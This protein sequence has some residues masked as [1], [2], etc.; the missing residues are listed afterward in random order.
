MVFCY[1]KFEH[2]KP[3]L[4]LHNFKQFYRLH[5]YYHVLS[6]PSKKLEK[7]PDLQS[8]WVLIVQ[9][10]K[11]NTRHLQKQEPS[12]LH[13]ANAKAP[14]TETVY[15]WMAS[16]MICRG[17]EI[18]FNMRQN[19]AS[20]DA[21]KIILKSLKS[22]RKNCWNNF[23][24][25]PRSTCVEVHFFRP[26]WLQIKNWKHIHSLPPQSK[27]RKKVFCTELQ[28]TTKTYKDDIFI[29]YVVPW[30]MDRKVFR[31]V[32]LRREYKEKNLKL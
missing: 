19:S 7:R 30:K 20:T 12:Y 18:K 17:P 25:F 3:S 26:L 4:E 21:E 15:Q 1:T 13:S 24:F 22:N 16:Q 11:R 23:V 10:C 31:R 8:C 5:K 29:C 6:P 2:F 32:E 9:A 28:Y 14:D 27:S